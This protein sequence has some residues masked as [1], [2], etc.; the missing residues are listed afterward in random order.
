MLEEQIVK[1]HGISITK[2]SWNKY[3]ENFGL[4]ATYGYDDKDLWVN[5][6]IILEAQMYILTN[7]TSRLQEIH[8]NRKEELHWEDE[9]NISEYILSDEGLNKLSK[10]LKSPLPREIYPDAVRDRDNL[11]RKINNLLENYDN[12]VVVTIKKENIHCSITVLVELKPLDNSKYCKPIFNTSK[13]TIVMSATI[14]KKDFY[15]KLTG[16]DPDRVK[17]IEI[18]SDFPVEIRHIYPAQIFYP[19][20]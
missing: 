7:L 1:F 14:L 11:T 19:S 9:K 3:I 6:L 8:T 20:L 10:Q 13:K 12:W 15:C 5:F 2:R 17:Y 18:P 4:P 16:L